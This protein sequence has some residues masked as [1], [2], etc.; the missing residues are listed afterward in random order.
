MVNLFS[1]GYQFRTSTAH[2]VAML[3]RGKTEQFQQCLI[4]WEFIKAPKSPCFEEL[5]S[6]LQLFPPKKFGEGK[7]LTLEGLG[8]DAKEQVNFPRHGLK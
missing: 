2:F 6:F 1:T 4:T 8:D 3:L 5:C 7:L